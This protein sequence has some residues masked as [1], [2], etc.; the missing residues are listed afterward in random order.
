MSEREGL[1][2]AEAKFARHA[3]TSV[4]TI[5]ILVQNGFGVQI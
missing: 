3:P 1:G 2:S 4:E 5:A